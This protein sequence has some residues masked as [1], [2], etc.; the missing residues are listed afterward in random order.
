M[1]HSSAVLLRHAV[2]RH[3]AGDISQAIVAYQRLLATDPR[4]PDA[5]H[6]LGVALAQRGAFNEA[7]P[8][9]RAAAELCPASAMVHLNLG[10]ALSS[11]ERYPEALQ[12][13]ERVTALEPQNAQTQVRRGIALAK[14]GRLVEAESSFVRGAVLNPQ[15]PDAHYNLGNLYGLERRHDL[16]VA[17]FSRALEF[18]P[19]YSD[20]RFNLALLRLLRGELRAGWELYEERFASDARRGAARR[21]AVPRWTGKEPIE[22]RRIL[23]W[24]ERGLGDTLQFCRYAPLVRDLGAAVTLEV[25]PR[26]KALLRS[27]FADLTVVGAN[28]HAES[29]DYE[30]PLLSVPRALGTELATIPARVPY[31]KVDRQA[32][33]RWAQRLPAD[34]SL[35]VGIAWQGNMEA[36][37]NWARGR[38]IPL[39]SLEPLASHPGVRLVSLQTGPGAVQL[40]SVG[41]ADRILSFGEALDAGPAAFMDTAAII[42]SLDLV[43]CCDSAVAHLAGALGAPVWVALH[44]TSE[45]RWLLDRSD[46]PWYPTMRLFRQTAPG[47]W[48]AV[49]RELCLAL[50]QLS[51]TRPAAQRSGADPR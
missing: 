28:E 31:L 48:Q 9:M 44:A 29:F 10:N 36:E 38:S 23:L 47:D 20:A 11:L 45:W 42:M 40:D 24:A 16:A 37:R 50:S 25:Q 18:H 26:L 39:S 15:D 35:R 7:V 49:V 14:L 8:L 13:Y 21:F 41:F 2:A 19:G 17:S 34:D 3:Q 33:E 32:V 51:S 43:I 4:N 46:S 12:C 1:S 6:M 27:P 30:C 22:G 5:L